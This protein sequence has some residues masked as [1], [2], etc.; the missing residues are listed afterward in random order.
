MCLRIF[1]TQLQFGFDGWIWVL[2]PSVPG[3]CTFVL[4]ITIYLYKTNDISVHC[5][6]MQIKIINGK[7]S[8]DLNR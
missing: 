1:K 7:K 8:N 3:I 5:T 2:I 4:L 6:Q